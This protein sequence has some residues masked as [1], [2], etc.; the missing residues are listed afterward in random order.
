MM[1][2]KNNLED[3]K[4]QL[5]NYDRTYHIGNHH[6]KILVYQPERNYKHTI[7]NYYELDFQTLCK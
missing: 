3:S 7:N 2:G 4:H 6:L 5:S 1:N